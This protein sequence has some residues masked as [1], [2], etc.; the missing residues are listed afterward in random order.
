MW[1][2]VFQKALH[3]A[4]CLVCTCH[5]SHEIGC[6]VTYIWQYLRWDFHAFV[7]VVCKLHWTFNLSGL[8]G[9]LSSFFLFS[10]F[11]FLL[12]PASSVFFS[13]PPSS[14]SR[15]FPFFFPFFLLFPFPSFFFFSF[16]VLL[17]LPPL[18]SLPSLFFSSFPLFCPFSSPLASVDPS[19]FLVVLE[20]SNLLAPILLLSC[21]AMDR[22]RSPHRPAAQLAGNRTLVNFPVWSGPNTSDNIQRGPGLQPGQT[23]PPQWNQSPRGFQPSQGIPLTQGSQQIPPGQVGNSQHFVV[24]I[25][26]DCP[27]PELGPKLWLSCCSTT[28]STRHWTGR[29]GTIIPTYSTYMDFL[30]ISRDIIDPHNMGLALHPLRDLLR[31]L[32]QV[33]LRQEHLLL[34][35]K[36]HWAEFQI[37]LWANIG[38]LMKNTMIPRSWMDSHYLEPSELPVGLNWRILKV[39]I[40]SLYLWVSSST[41]EVRTIGCA[42]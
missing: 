26:A 40:R 14:S 25:W 38:N 29:Y 22:S 34:L 28:P 15:L 9:A 24:T 19:P 8:S 2:C 11:P 13:C 20:V 35:A 10:F 6:F 32:H 30:P 12:F 36:L 31:S 3:F 18:S 33:D 42:N 39:V 27:N 5:V 1:L 16:L 41:K 37:Y 4:A 7:L 17:S 21:T 23:H